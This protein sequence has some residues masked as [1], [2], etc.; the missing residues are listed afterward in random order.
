MKWWQ[1]DASDWLSFT[2]LCGF[3]ITMMVVL[4]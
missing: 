2:V 1:R 3:I 4:P